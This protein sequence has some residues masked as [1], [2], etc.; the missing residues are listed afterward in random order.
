MNQIDIIIS[1][2][3]IAG[4][5][6]ALLLAQS[7]FDVAL[8]EPFP[9]KQP[10][11]SARTVALMQSSLN[12]INACDGIW[13][14]IADLAT[15]M[16]KMRL[17]DISRPVKEPVISEF[18][19]SD[20]DMN[21]FGYNIPND[22]LRFS[23]FEKAKTHKRVTLFADALESYELSSSH[24]KVRLAD[25]KVIDGRLIIGADGRGSKV[26]EIAD[27]KAK[28]KPYDQIAITC[29][30]N[31]NRSHENTSTEFHKSGGPLALV[32]L[33]GNQ[34]SVVWVENKERA[35]EII[36]LPKS[37]VEEMLMEKSQNIL[38]AITLEGGLES[39][40]LCTI[41]AEKL[42]APRCALIAEAAHVMSPI[43]AQ[44]LNLSLRDVAALAE[45]LVD[46][47][48]LG[49]DIGSASV[50]QKYEALRFHDVGSRIFGVDGMNK[51]V[52]SDRKGVKELRR[53]GLKA[54]DNLPLLK[55]YA[56]QI[57]LAPQKDLSRLGKGGVL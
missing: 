21:A 7:D 45:I 22:H 11:Q 53:L 28:K 49:L 12:V 43:T 17:I 10:G 39:W 51:L 44:G 19:A 54:I 2:G 35:E 29:L 6:L 48:R 5:T 52:S 42:T 23:L 50:L 56:M 55:N 47:A 24:I 41:K 31:H 14:E 57:G 32:P 38:G 40:P 37:E 26:R 25:G 30:I 34:S 36:R 16:E 3:G 8:I 9:P 27:I 20:I 1:G 13:A 4:T 33:I 46:H 18:A 15:P